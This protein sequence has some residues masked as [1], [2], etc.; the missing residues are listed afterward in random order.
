MTDISAVF[1]DGRTARGYAVTLRFDAAGGLE[2]LG[3]ERPLRY[4]A[5]ELRIS[6][7]VGDT[8]RSIALPDGAKCETDSNDALDAVLARRGAE[9]GGRLLHLLENRWTYLLLLFALT[10]GVVWGIVKFG[11]PELAR[12]AAFAMPV[13]ASR[14]LGR[15]VLETLDS[16]A[17]SSSG[18][19]AARKAALQ[20]R[21]F[22]MTR[23]LNEAYKFR[24]E[25]R[26]SPL[27]GPNALALPD[28]TIVVTD[29]LVR[30]AR[31]DEELLAVLAHEIGH[32]VHRHALR[33]VLQ[34]SAV[35]LIVAFAVGDVV[36]L[37]SL[38]AALPTMLVE[39]QFSRDFEREADAF[40]LQIMRARKIPPHHAAAILTRL[41]E[42]HG[43]KEERFNYLSSHP[44]TEERIR[45]FGAER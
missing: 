26:R 18:L 23:D 6:S 27:L 28:G 11:V 13:D 30:L 44:A 32:V 19:E 25:F 22:E 12:Q 43:R 20:A 8:P 35:A 17:L 10:S 40:A 24:L 34:S 31:G 14:A 4:A 5:G 21:F 38:A 1:Y 41:A 42:R 16:G 33:G 39:A 45:I 37:T 3:L 9:A 29:E 2:I 36:S 15:G 7:R